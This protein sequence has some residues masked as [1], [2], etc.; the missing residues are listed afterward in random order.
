MTVSQPLEFTQQECRPLSE[1][2]VLGRHESGFGHRVV[3][4]EGFAEPELYCV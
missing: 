4:A 1:P 2:L 3:V